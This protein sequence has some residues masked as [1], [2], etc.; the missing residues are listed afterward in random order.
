[1]D[2]FNELRH[3]TEETTNTW[4]TP[5]YIF[6]P[7]GPFDLDPC[8]PPNMPWKTARFMLTEEEDGLK[9]PWKED[10]FVFCNPPYGKETEVWL[11]KM[12]KHNHGIALVY[13]RTETK[14]FQEHVWGKATAILFLHKR[15][16]F[17]GPDGNP[18]I[19][20]KTGKPSGSGGA[21]SV[22]IA[23][24]H[25]AM[26]RLEEQHGKL[27]YVVVDEWVAYPEKKKKNHLTKK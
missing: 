20:P 12:A 2:R 21:P 27:G 15:V 10:H 25:E 18:V 8:C 22:L 3:K 1:M 23:Y 11:N 5:P 13:A 16:S 24:G 4:L 19:N 6:K 14:A 26:A 17:L 7:L 9:T